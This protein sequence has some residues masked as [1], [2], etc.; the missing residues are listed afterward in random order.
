MASPSTSKYDTWNKDNEILLYWFKMHF[1]KL[2]L[3]LFYLRE[4]EHKSNRYLMK[5]LSFA[6]SRLEKA[7]VMTKSNSYYLKFY[8]ENLKKKKKQNTSFRL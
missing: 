7:Y 4:K 8:G 6:W 3:T 1:K 5:Y 2:N